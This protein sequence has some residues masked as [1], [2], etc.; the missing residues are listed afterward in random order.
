MASTGLE[1]QPSSFIHGS[2]SGLGKHAQVNF[3]DI[4]HICVCC[5]PEQN[6]KRKV[7]TDDV[8]VE[9][10]CFSVPFLFAAFR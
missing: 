2:T 5:K 4:S 3:T 7:I 6:T 8:D 10:T 9:L 1:Q